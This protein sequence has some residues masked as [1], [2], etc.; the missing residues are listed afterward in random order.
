MCC[1]GIATLAGCE[2]PSFP[3]HHSTYYFGSKPVRRIHLKKIHLTNSI[4]EAIVD[5]EDYERVI[6]HNWYINNVG[7]AS[8][9]IKGKDIFLH[10]FVMGEKKGL[11]IDHIDQNKLNCSKDNLRFC[12]HSQNT[13][14]CG[15]KKNNKLGIKGVDFQQGKY[16]ATIRFNYKKIFIGYFDTLR[17]AAAAWNEASKKYFGEFAYQNKLE[18][19]S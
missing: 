2:T 19:L 10:Y 16:R 11:E 13:A 8:T 5:D 1:D 3:V 15:P 7:Y 17:E 14:N 9:S 4:L 6:K 18:E 12:T